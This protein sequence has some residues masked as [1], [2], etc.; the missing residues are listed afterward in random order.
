M[1]DSYRKWDV[2][3]PV[4]HNDRG[5]KLLLL[6]NGY[7]TSMKLPKHETLIALKPDK[8][9]YMDAQTYLYENHEKGDWI[10]NQVRVNKMFAKAFG[11]QI[12]AANI[13]TATT[14]EVV[15]GVTFIHFNISLQLP[16]STIKLLIDKFTALINNNSVA[17]NF[18]YLDKEGALG[19]EFLECF[20]RSTFS[21]SE[22]QVNSNGN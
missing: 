4:S 21:G 22:R 16:N 11:K 6:A 14:W 3:D 5:A 12:L 9:N 2:T 19:K 18:L 15:G 1:P 10:N 13:D 17:I 8:A 7:D 20:K